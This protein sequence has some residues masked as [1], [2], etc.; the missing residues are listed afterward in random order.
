MPENTLFEVLILV[1]RPASGKSEILEYLYNIE[2]KIRREKYHIGKLDVIDDFPMLWTWFEE[3]TILSEKFGVPR[4]H[5]D[6]NRYFKYPYLWN[7]LI[8]RINLEYFKR[9]RDENNYHQH[10]TTIIEFAR[11]TEHGGYKQAFDFLS[12]QILAR[13]GIMYVEVSFEESRRKNRQRFNPE[14]PDSILE[15]AVDEEKLEILYRYDDWRD[16]FSKAESGKYLSIREHQVPCVVFKNE[17]D[18]TTQGGTALGS[19]LE[20]LLDNLWQIMNQGER[21]EG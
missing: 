5:S 8:E 1:G 20:D 2:D 21:V 11:G 14:K 10:T 15:H 3:D 6:D 19:R 13:A 16:L 7:L 18:V 17:D 4:L 12:D 9:T